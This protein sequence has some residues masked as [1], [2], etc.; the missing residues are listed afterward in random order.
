VAWHLEREHERITRT[1]SS[2]GVP[3]RLAGVALGAAD[4]MLGLA[5]RTVRLP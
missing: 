2:Q 4:G 5:R 1:R 3:Y